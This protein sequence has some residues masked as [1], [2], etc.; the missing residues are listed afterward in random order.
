MSKRPILIVGEDERGMPAA[1]DAETHRVLS[2]FAFVDF[3]EVERFIAWLAPHQ[4][5]YAADS[6]VRDREETAWA[7][8][9][10]WQQCCTPGCNHHAHPDGVLCDGCKEDAD[11]APT[12]VSSATRRMVERAETG[13][14]ADWCAQMN[15]GEV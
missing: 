14:A 1:L 15:A 8:E 3:A 4:G 13:E 12:L 5:L 7:R 11:S 6:R 9:R 2:L 10:D